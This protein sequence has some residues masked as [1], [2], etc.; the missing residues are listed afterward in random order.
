MAGQAVVMAS[1]AGILFAMRRMRPHLL[2]LIA[3]RPFA[4][5]HPALGA[6]VAS[7][8]EL[9]QPDALDEIFDLLDSVVESDQKGRTPLSCWQIS[10]TTT[11]VA[12]AVHRMCKTAEKEHFHASAYVRQDVLPQIRA[13]LDA[14]L[15]NHLLG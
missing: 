7:L 5:A 14:I 3:C 12:N 8:T 15:H 2:P 4:K 1:A 6:L 11:S 10:R 13:H 9:G